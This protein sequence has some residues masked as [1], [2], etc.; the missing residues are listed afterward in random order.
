MAAC[1]QSINNPILSGRIE[2]TRY[3]MWIAALASS[4][5]LLQFLF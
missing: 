5:N 3:L 2:P 4:T 1:L